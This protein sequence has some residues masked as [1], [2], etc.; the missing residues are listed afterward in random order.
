[1]LLTKPIKRTLNK[2]GCINLTNLTATER[3][4]LNGMSR[5]REA[6]LH[7]GDKLF[8]AI[9]LI[10]KSG[11]PNNAI[12]AGE[13]L[14]VS[15]VVVHGETITINNPAVAGTDVY[16]FLADTAQ[17]KTVATNKAVNISASATKASGTL[18]M[19]TQPVSGNT[20]TIGSKTYIFVP[21]GTDTADGEVSIGANLA[22]AQEALV[23]AINGTDGISDPHPLVRA[24]AFAANASVITA[25]IGGTSGNSIVTTE[26]FTAVSNVFAAATLGSGADCAAAN[27]ITALVAAITASDT[28]GVGAVDGTGDTVVITADTAGVSGNAI[29]IGE[30]L[31]NGAFTGGAVAL[32]GGVDGTPVDGPGFMMDE[33]YLYVCVADNTVAGKNWRRVSIGSF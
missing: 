23:A 3:K 18:T 19:D 5:V 21:V 32:S 28:Q 20:V 14:T 8:E 22:G 4:I 30:T 2:K 27:A 1:M 29:A 17:T 7:L 16:E 10:G 12:N 15:G 11:T 13:T 24:G 6:S 9:E 25:L 31:A 33:S 26:T